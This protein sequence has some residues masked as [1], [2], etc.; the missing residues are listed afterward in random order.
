MATSCGTILLCSFFEDNMS[1]PIPTNMLNLPASV[2]IELIV[3]Y[4]FD[5][6]NAIA[7]IAQM[8][9]F[10][11]GALLIAWSSLQMTL[12]IFVWALMYSKICVNT[13]KA[14]FLKTLFGKKFYG[15]V[16]F[17]DK[18]E[19]SQGI[20]FRIKRY[21]YVIWIRYEGVIYPYLL[22]HAP[23]YIKEPIMCEMYM[24]YINDSVIFK[25]CHYDFKRQLLCNLKPIFY[26][27]GDY[28]TFKGTMD[29][30][31]YC[32]SIGT[33]EVLDEDNYGNETIIGTLNSNNW[34][35][36]VQ[37]VD[38]LVGQKY[39]YKSIDYTV[40]LTLH[41]NDWKYLLEFFPASYM[42]IVKEIAVY[43]E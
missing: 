31:M 13:F 33:I 22:K 3:T 4:L 12:Y 20:A 34:F 11:N 43:E 10:P 18:Q 42:T 21:L 6:M 1:I 30:N 5:K 36:V 27:P 7:R 8:R 41:M 29:N 38:S 28:V 32:I 25:K 40:V 16:D 14:H 15:V 17:L 23:I 35:G 2:K 26:L 9:I 24:S 39:N 19:I 37:G